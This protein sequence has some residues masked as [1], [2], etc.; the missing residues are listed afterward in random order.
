MV[1]L[2]CGVLGLTACTSDDSTT[3]EA[4]PSVIAPGK[5]GE[6]NRTLSPDEAKSSTPNE[7]PNDADFTYVEMMIVHHQQA[8]EMTDLAAKEATRKQVKGIASRIADAQGPEIKMMNKWL[9][10]NGRKPVEAQDE[11]GGHGGAGHGGMPGMASD[12]EMKELA[13][14]RGAE[15]D[16]LF[17]RL[18]IEHHEGALTMAREVQNSGSVVR[19]QEMADDVIATQ[20]AEINKMER[21]LASS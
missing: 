13:D 12:E 7:E 8:I 9:E 10:D 19:V 11:H 4:G 16:R 2:V 15:F 21:M 5:P 18:M 14:A 20:S 3:G 6:S 1:V 17:L